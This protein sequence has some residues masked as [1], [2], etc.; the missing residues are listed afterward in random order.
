MLSEFHYYA[1]QDLT[2]N[3]LIIEEKSEFRYLEAKESQ[4]IYAYDAKN[5]EER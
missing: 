1:V 4:N 5:T 3:G 2:V